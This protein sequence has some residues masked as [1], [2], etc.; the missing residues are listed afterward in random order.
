MNGVK[1]RRRRPIDIM[2]YIESTD[3]QEDT[4]TAVTAPSSIVIDPGSEGDE[5]TLLD[6]DGKVRMVFKGLKTYRIV[7]GKKVLW[8][9]EKNAPSKG[10]RELFLSNGDEWIQINCVVI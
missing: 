2:D 8:D 3:K 9:V 6:G 10:G 7:D 1:S 4:A 5:L